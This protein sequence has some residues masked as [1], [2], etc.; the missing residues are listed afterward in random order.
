MPSLISH[1]NNILFSKRKDV[2]MM[3]P[4]IITLI[5]EGISVCMSQKSVINKYLTVLRKTSLKMPEN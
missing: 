1:I 5:E 3:K 2:L 4:M